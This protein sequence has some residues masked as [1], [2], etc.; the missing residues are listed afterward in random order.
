VDVD[1]EETLDPQNA[2]ETLDPQDWEAMRRLGHRMVDEVIAYHRE[3]GE[4]PAWKAPD[5]E[6]ISAMRTAFPR[7]GEGAESVF[8]EFVEHVLPFP[9][10]NIHPRAWG[11]VNGTGTT[12]A[13][14]A[15]MLAAA[16]NPNVWAGQHAAPH[17]E[18]TV[19]DFVKSVV[20]FGD[21]A[22]AVLVSG[23]STANLVCLAAG[24]DA[25]AGE[26]PSRTGLHALGVPM[27]MY[28]SEQVHNSVHKAAGLLGIGWEGVRSIPVDDGY[29]MDIGHLEQAIDA[30]LQNGV[31]PT[32]VIATA[33]TVNTGAIDDLD[34]IADVCARYDL[35]MHVDGAFGAMAG[36]S[37]T[38]R[39]LVHGIERADSV[40]LDL[41]KW[42][43]V[44][45]GVAC[46]L[47]KD[48][49]AHRA[50]FSPP[51]SYLTRL[52]RGVAS[53]PENFSVLSPEL[54]RPFRALKVWF[55][56]RTHGTA[57][58]ARLVEQNV[59]QAR[60]LA[61]RITG[62]ADLELMAP[63]ALNVVCYRFRAD[64]LDAIALDA[65]N[66]E[67][68]LQIQESGTAVPSSTVLRG[69][70][71]L[72]CAMTNHRTKRSDLDRL[73]DASVRIGR[74]ILLGAGVD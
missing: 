17:I 13:A 58:Y 26:A 59:E 22:S 46:A 50:P 41:H 65:L 57:R 45:I 29:R 34:A 43:Y 18:A 11:W 24:R 4:R 70:F 23:A 8:R 62:S 63:V 61:G 42:L 67:L 10:G 35:W 20:G 32:C 38:L 51:A 53:G 3:I 30:D 72:R 21:T 27:A 14:Y 16:M 7:E 33:G 68:L 52:D 74:E 56:L 19:L 6:S 12:E 39:P 54:T 2:E 71:V 9:Y 31:R 15:D 55:S 5:A 73:V 69:A 60:Y 64:G 28:A 48:A 25:T 37:D 49:A 44:P 36:L 47:V 1:G 40:A 66:R